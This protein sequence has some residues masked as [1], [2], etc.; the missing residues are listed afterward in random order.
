MASF[1]PVQVARARVHFG[2]S[3]NGL[4][5]SRVAQDFWL[6]A[7]IMTLDFVQMASFAFQVG[8][9]AVLVVSHTRLV[10]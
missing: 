5:V 4:I 1:L 9:S 2:G 7:F 3:V 10:D 6:V 8:E